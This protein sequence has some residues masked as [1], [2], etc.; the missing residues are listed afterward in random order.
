MWRRL[1]LPV[2]AF[3]VLTACDM[4]LYESVVKPK[5]DRALMEEARIKID[6]QDYDGALSSLDKVGRDSNDLRL[7]RSAARLGQSGLSMWT[8]L[9]DI[10]D[11]TGFDSGT[12]SGVD[13][14]F[15]Q[16]SGAVVGEGEART[17][18]L[19]ALTESVSDLL[20]APDPNA[21]R[22]KNLACFLAGVMALPTV[23]DATTAI[24]STTTSLAS[25]AATV[26]VSNPNAQCPD[27]SGLNSSLTTIANVQN[28][29]SLI[30]E[31]TANCKL[32]D[33]TGTGSDLNAIEAQLAKFNQNA[34]AGC[35]STPACGS[36]AACQALGLQCVYDALTTGSGVSTAQDGQV[37]KC[38]L[39]QNCLTPG[40]CF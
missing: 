9:T 32:L 13:N 18:R 15:D 24:Q 7:L 36:G 12:G 1:M 37:S 3:W 8:I 25:L 34:D 21:S 16:I 10:V 2:T 14:F 6:E 33:V 5:T 19:A 28:Q 4:N 22:V 29:F 11:G 30:L 35:S 40:T 38:E 27:L 20:Q 23:T 31:A 17:L 39:V 26:D